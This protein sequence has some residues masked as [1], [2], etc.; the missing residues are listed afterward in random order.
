MTHQTLKAKRCELYM[1]PEEMAEALGFDLSQYLAMEDGYGREDDTQSAVELAQSLKPKVQ[2]GLRKEITEYITEKGDIREL[3]GLSGLPY[4]FVNQLYRGKTRATTAAV[5]R[6][7]G[8]IA[9]KKF[10]EMADGYEV[11]LTAPKAVAPPPPAPPAPPAP[12]P[13][14][15]KEIEVSTDTIPRPPAD[16]I[17]PVLYV[18]A[19]LVGSWL[20]QQVG[21]PTPITLYPSVGGVLA[22][23]D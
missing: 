12:P 1:T 3:A 5:T 13:N 7:R 6:I 2:T 15:C 20:A 22:V 17:S 14:P 16:K 4:D 8:A 23:V 11:S 18:P 19:D 10:E 9:G 21:K